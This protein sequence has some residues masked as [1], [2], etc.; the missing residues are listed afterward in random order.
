M[1]HKNGGKRGLDIWLLGGQSNM[2]GRGQV[3]ELT[4]RS[5]GSDDG[6]AVFKGDNTWVAPATHPLHR[7]VDLCKADRCGVGPGLPFATGLLNLEPTMGTIGLIPC[8]LGK[9]KLR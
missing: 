5:V 8:A 1:D 9:Y 2:A 7:D 4:P 3:T 6:V